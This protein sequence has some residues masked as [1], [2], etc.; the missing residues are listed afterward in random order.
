MPHTCQ[1]CNQTS[2]RYNPDEYDLGCRGHDVTCKDCDR[3]FTRCVECGR[4]FHGRN[5]TDSLNQLREH[6]KTHRP[7]NIVCPVCRS[8]EKKF[9]SGADAVL[10]VESGYCPGCRGRDN[11]ERQI[12]NFVRRQAPGLINNQLMIEYGDS[13]V[14]SNAYSCSYCNKAFSK[15][16]AL[17]QHQSS[18][19]DGGNTSHL[20]IGGY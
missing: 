2:N 14:P 9:K 13:A 4:E 6:Q 7:K 19:H 15:L 1:I 10:H 17:M 3:D 11:A 8:Q 5:M 16:S 18:K 20:R 12:Y